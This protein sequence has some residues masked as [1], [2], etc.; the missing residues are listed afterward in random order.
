VSRRNTN[1]TLTP[2][3][4]ASQT[5]GD[6]NWHDLHAGDRIATD[7]NGEAEVNIQNCMQVY[8]FKESQ[9]VSSP[10]PKGASHGGSVICAA[11]GTSLFNNACGSRLSIQTDSAEITVEGTY[12]SV[13]YLPADELTL[14]V[15][16][17]GK[18]SVRSTASSAEGAPRE[19]VFVEEGQFVISLPETKKSSV[20]QLDPTLVSGKPD[21]LDRLPDV[22]TTLKLEPWLTK[23]GERAKADNISLQLPALNRV[24]DSNQSLIDCDCDNV[25]AG[26]GTGAYQRECRAT[27]QRLKEELAQTGKVTGKCHSI[28]SGPNARPK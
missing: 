12:F 20:S 21:S 16:L 9:L 7:E 17:K 1:V 3:Q 23:I 4:K 26:F 25:S 8:V 15:V 22:A 19:P 5:L 27:E 24:A 18:V 2:L 13:T 6:D 28:A 14:V 10:C 11:V